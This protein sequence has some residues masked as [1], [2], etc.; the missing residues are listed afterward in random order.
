MGDMAADMERVEKEKA[1]KARKRIRAAAA[2]MAGEDEGADEKEGILSF[3]WAKPKYMK[4]REW[5]L[6]QAE[7]GRGELENFLQTLPFETYELY[8]GT[9]KPKRA[10]GGKLNPLT[11]FRC[12]FKVSFLAPHCPALP[13]IALSAL[14]FLVA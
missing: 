12:V 5:W 3:R 6:R 14:P 8:R 9:E 13:R 7:P 10:T 1:M 4:D 11:W 2:K